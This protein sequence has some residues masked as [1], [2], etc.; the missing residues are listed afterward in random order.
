MLDSSLLR[1]GMNGRRELTWEVERAAEGTKPYSR[2][3]AVSCRIDSHPA[4]DNRS[5]EAMHLHVTCTVVTK[6]I[7]VTKTREIYHSQYIKHQPI[8]TSEYLN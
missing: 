7:L 8:N 3:I 2:R 4:S 1:M 5:I 6:E